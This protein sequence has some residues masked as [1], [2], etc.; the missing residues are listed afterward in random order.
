MLHR[1]YLKVQKQNYQSREI[2]SQPKGSA[3]GVK[4]SVAK[5]KMADAVLYKTN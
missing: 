1:E 4:T 2:S 5:K 3:G